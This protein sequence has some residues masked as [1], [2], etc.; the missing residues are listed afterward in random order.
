MP[1][2]GQNGWTQAGT[3]PDLLCVQA[4]AT[5]FPWA[6]E[7]PRG[8]AAL[9]GERNLQVGLPVRWELCA[10]CVLAMQTLCSLRGPEEATS[11]LLILHTFPPPPPALEQNGFG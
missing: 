4:T 10:G 5:P 1:E 6:T 3:S 8:L 2:S 9:F 11:M 7:A